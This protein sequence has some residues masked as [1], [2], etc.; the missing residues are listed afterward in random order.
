MSLVF[1]S[2]APNI[3]TQLW[4]KSPSL[5]EKQREGI[6]PRPRL[7]LSFP[8]NP[9]PTPWSLP[10]LSPGPAGR[11][12]GPG[13]GGREGSVGGRLVAR[14][15]AICSLLQPG[16]LRREAGAGAGAAGR[17]AAGR[18]SCWAGSTTPPP[19]GHS[20]GHILEPEQGPPCAEPTG[21]RTRYRGG[22]KGSSSPPFISFQK[23][24]RTKSAQLC[25]R[26]AEM[27][28]TS[29]LFQLS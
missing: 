29:I 28:I 24:T 7:P 18:G 10:A 25:A 14:G 3:H 27:T 8:S 21:R 5:G 26:R 17:G 1:S 4:S 11:R 6:P 15:A 9:P 2:P 20:Q 16:G 22:K 13:H 12:Q 23:S 19:Y